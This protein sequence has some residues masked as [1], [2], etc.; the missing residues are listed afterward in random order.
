MFHTV[1]I[2]NLGWNDDEKRRYIHMND[3]RKTET[4]NPSSKA[5]RDAGKAQK[6]NF[7]T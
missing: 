7:T 4:T 6:K 1:N 5:K 3:H 2:P